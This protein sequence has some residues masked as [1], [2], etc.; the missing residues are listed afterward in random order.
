MRVALSL[1]PEAD[2]LAAILPLLS[3]GEVDALEWSMDLGWGTSPPPWVA[4]LL[5]AY[6]AQGALYGHGVHL[7]V[8]SA[9]PTTPRQHQWLSNLRQEVQGRPY[10]HIS[11]HF[12]WSSAGPFGQGAPLPLP[13]SRAA[14]AVGRERLA[15]LAE[16]SA[17]A[18]VPVGL[19]NLALSLSARDAEALPDFLEALVAPVAGFLVLDLHNLWCQAVNFALDPLRLLERYPREQVRELHVSG[20]SWAQAAGRRFR[21]DTHDGP[22]PPPVLALLE[23]ALTHFPAVEV[24]T[25]E[26]MSGTLRSPAEQHAFAQEFRTIRA[27]CQ[28]TAPASS[29]SIPVP[30]PPRAVEEEE[31]EE[32]E[33]WALAEAQRAWLLA[34]SGEG[35]GEGEGGVLSGWRGAGDGAALETVA[36]LAARWLRRSS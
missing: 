7:S 36:V 24:V 18:S 17:A 30:A 28:Q 3:A 22:V 14:L 2:F 15:A 4:S 5:A 8:L 16:C 35:E 21:R 9:E 33:R 34:L 6:G 19:E 1:M 13:R 26:R 12:G 32:V 20:G 27:R 31:E 25:L 11:E 10:R 29:S 23:A